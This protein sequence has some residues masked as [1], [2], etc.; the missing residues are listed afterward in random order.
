MT[1]VPIDSQIKC[2]ARELAYRARVYPRLISAGKMTNAKA[3]HEI[4]VMQAVLETLQKIEKDER[5][6]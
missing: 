5:L 3:E 2:V 4:T 6:V 1:A